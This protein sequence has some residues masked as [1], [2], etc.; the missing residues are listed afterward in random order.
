ME[1]EDQYDGSDLD[2]SEHED[3]SDYTSSDSDSNTETTNK[4][5]K[6][7]LTRL[8]K[9]RTEHTNSGGRKKRVKFDEFGRFVGKYRSQLPSYLGYLVRE[10]VGVSVFNWKKVTKEVNEKIWE[11]IMVNNKV[12]A[13]DEI[14]PRSLM[15]CKGCENKAGEIEDANVKLMAEKLVEH[16]KQIKDGDVMLDPGMDAITKGSSKEQIADLKFELQNERL[17]LQKKDEE[18][19][20]LSTKVREQDKTLKL[21]LAHLES[22]GTMIPNLTSHLNQSPTQVLSVD[23]NVES[24]GTLVTNTIIEKAPIT[25]KALSN[26][27]VTRVMTKT[28]KI[29][30][31]SKSVTTNSHPK[32][33]DTHSP[34][35]PQTMKTMK[36][37]LQYPDN[38]SNVAYGIIYISS[39]RQAIH[40]VPLQDDCYKVS[41]DE[42]I[43]GAAFLP[44]QN[45]DI[46]TVEG[47]IKLLLHGQN[48][49]SNVTK[50]YHE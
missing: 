38:R 1:E 48:T 16:E 26:E 24:H 14:P 41:I 46:K 12:L 25:D 34:K 20:A 21:V 10:R 17:Q 49:L 2:D 47:H 11:E 40:G 35:L 32:T 27:P 3:K 36:C 28:G 50:K 13:K 6:R 45:G 9:L 15:W 29:T 44:Y 31:E 39:E 18:L 37:I 22:Q 30:V 23:K 8:P 42:V 33:K 43:K 4:T 19:K 5:R 7:G